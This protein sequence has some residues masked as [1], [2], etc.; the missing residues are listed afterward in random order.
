MI[1][2]RPKL[3]G[4]TELYP[5]NFLSRLA[6]SETIS[7]ATVTASVYTGSDTDPA[8]IL[9]GSPSI[10]GTTVTQLVTGGVIGTIYRLLYQAVTSAG[11]TLELEALL[12]VP[13]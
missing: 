7:S 10:S 5:V 11:Q 4:E 8:A 9:S 1:S 3:I 2:L 6:T 12:A 13:E